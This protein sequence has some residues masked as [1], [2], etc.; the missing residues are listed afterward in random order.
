VSDESLEIPRLNPP[1]PPAD[2]AEGPTAP[3]EL[4]VRHAVKDGRTVALL[5]AIDYGDACVVEA[6][7]FAQGSAAPT[8]PGPYTFG[9]AHDATTFVTDAV[10][11]L[12]Y[13]GCEIH[14]Q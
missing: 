3:R 4:F 1:A 5:R 13:L 7:V 2:A 9:D 14:A 10:E 12:M 8:F 6:H 11:A